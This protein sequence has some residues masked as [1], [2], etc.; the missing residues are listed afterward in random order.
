[1][2]SNSFATLLS[3]DAIRPRNGVITFGFV[4][5]NNR[6][7]DVVQQNIRYL[8]KNLIEPF[9]N[10]RFVETSGEGNINFQ[11]HDNSDYYAYEL[12]H[13]V[14]LARRQD[15]GNDPSTSTSTD[16]FQNGFGSHGFM[17]LVHETLHALGL[18]HPG[19]Y[20]G[21]EGGTGPFLPYA[22]DNTTNSIMSYNFAGEG[23][24]TPMPYDIAAL[25]YLYGARNLNSGNTTYQFSS[26]YSFSD[27]DRTWGSARAA[28]KLTLWDQG[29]TDTLDFSRLSSDASGYYL[30]AS[31]GG[32]LTTHQALNA[33]EYKPKDTTNPHTARQKTSPYGTRLTFN[34]QVEKIVGSHSRDTI[35]AGDYTQ[36]IW[37]LGGH[38]SIT[39]SA[40]SDRL[41]GG[42]GNDMLTGGGGDD[43]LA[44][45]DRIVSNEQDHLYG[46]AGRDSFILGSNQGS[47]YQGN[48]HAV[49]KD[50]QA[51]QDKI[52]L[53]RTSGRYSTQFQ[54]LSGGAA[55]DTG[56][57]HNNDLI[58][59]IEDSTNV[60]V[61][62]GDFAFV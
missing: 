6:V 13:D 12:D 51:G 54:K 25:Q 24:I 27:G 42:D 20:N 60:S 16:G 47:F 52:L 62:R 55:L 17:T 9:I 33:F 45:S 14:Y 59:V 36:Q 37:G 31:A 48:G 5:G 18:K 26:V 38:D 58:G 28:S 2:F 1:M 46:G 41:W 11:L 4:G 21:E 19:N 61:A 43:R 8:F 35:L 39:G 57:Y 32:I 30:D 15:I 7:S 10:V 53:G 3:P 44:G 34:T 40:Q 56:I 49:I 50:W 22:A 29:G 23:A